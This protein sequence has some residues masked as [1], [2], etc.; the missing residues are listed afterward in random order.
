MF[1]DGVV[2]ALPDGVVG[3]GNGLCRSLLETA[4]GFA[5]RFLEIFFASGAVL[6]VS[7]EIG[8]AA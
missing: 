7:F 1:F 2:T 5:P 8:D 6:G 4:L 3:E